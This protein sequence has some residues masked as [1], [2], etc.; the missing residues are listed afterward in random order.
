MD[1]AFKRIENYFLCPERYQKI[2]LSPHDIR[3]KVFDEIQKTGCCY[4][5]SERDKLGRRVLLM[6]HGRLDTEKFSAGDGIRFLL[7]VSM[8]LI[9]EQETQIAGMVSIFNFEGTSLK[10]VPSLSELNDL[11]HF[12]QNAG[13]VRHRR[14][15]FVGLPLFA[16]FL[17]DQLK[18][19]MSAK[20]QKRIQVVK[21]FKELATFFDPALLPKELGGVKLEAEKLL[22]FQKLKEEKMK[23]LDSIANFKVDMKKVP[24]E[25][26]WSDGCQESVG[27]FRK[28]EID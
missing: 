19:F 8:I 13:V 26:I 10:H 5:L 21:D 14:Y 1:G 22:E 15:F 6:Q 4:P 2:K 18:G 3:L 11:M 7:F 12:A 9:E 23:D 16:S 27:S 25:R 24:A 28:L 17:V 20:L